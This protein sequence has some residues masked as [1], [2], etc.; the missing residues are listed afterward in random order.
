MTAFRP[1]NMIQ[2]SKCDRPRLIP[3]GVWSVWSPADVQGYY[4][5]VPWNDAA[6][7][8]QHNNR[9][10]IGSTLTVHTKWMRSLQHG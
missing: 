8:W 2:L 4:W 7:R 5:V 10:T 1:G 9:I 6:R 3:D